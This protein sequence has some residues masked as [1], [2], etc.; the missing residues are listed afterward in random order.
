MQIKEVFMKN[1]IKLFVLLSVILITFSCDNSVSP[2][3]D[4]FAMYLLK[5]DSLTTLDVEKL[6]ISKLE[7]RS[8]PV[9]TYE[10][11]IS[12]DSEIHIISLSKNLRKYLEGDSTK[13]FS[14]ILGV[15][16]VV[17]ANGERIYLGSFVT[18]I[19]SW[20]PNTPIIREWPID[21]EEKSIAIEK[22]PNY[23]E[24]SFVDVRNDNR[25]LTALKGKL[26]KK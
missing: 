5:E 22:A 21:D 6:S 12:Y 24:N 20:L 15:P 4:R 16:F 10:D 11:I 8:K 7:L 13:I 25:I 9:F 3:N 18:L 1:I 19:S 26:V 14:K 23:D 17:V 2:E